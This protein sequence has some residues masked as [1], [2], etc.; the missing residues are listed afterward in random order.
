MKQLRMYL[1]KGSCWLILVSPVK[2]NSNGLMSCLEK[3]VEE[4]TCSSAAW[5]F[6]QSPQ[7][8]PHFAAPGF[9]ILVQW[10]EGL[11]EETEMEKKIQIPKLGA[12]KWSDL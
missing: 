10:V 3:F 2:L 6:A 4:K 1:L 9:L 8:M 5:A 11:R 12:I 7:E